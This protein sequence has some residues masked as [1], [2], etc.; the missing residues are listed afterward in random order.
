VIC[1]LRL[2]LFDLG[3]QLSTFGTS[4]VN[5]RLDILP[6]TGYGFL[7][8]G[9]E[10]LSA[11]Q[12]GNEVIEGLIDAAVLRHDRVALSR[13]GFVLVLLGPYSFIF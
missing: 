4:V 13:E 9:V 11:H 8:F 5:K 3:E 10:A 7:H 12:A 6:Y 1:T 2:A